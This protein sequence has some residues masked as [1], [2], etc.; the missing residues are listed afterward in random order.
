[1][2]NF[3]P[4]FLVSPFELAGSGGVAGP[5]PGPGIGYRSIPN[6]PYMGERSRGQSTHNAPP[7]PKSHII[8]SRLRAKNAHT[9]ERGRNKEQQSCSWCGF[10]NFL[11]SPLPSRRPTNTPRDLSG[12]VDW[13][14]GKVEEGK[15]QTAMAKF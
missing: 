11:F 8:K 3:K 7:P 9:T 15:E 10:C 13:L 6:L 1:M 5:S 4:L 14:V 12:A 2:Y